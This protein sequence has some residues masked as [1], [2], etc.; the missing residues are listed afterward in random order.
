MILLALAKSELGHP[1]AEVE[2]LSRKAVKADPK[3][4]KGW[5][6]LAAYLEDIGKHEESDQAHYEF[7]KRKLGGEAVEFGLAEGLPAGLL[8]TKKGVE[9]LRK[10]GLISDGDPALN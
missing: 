3:N 7:C 1:P 9:L 10:D 8:V 5:Q 4:L 2:A 6:W